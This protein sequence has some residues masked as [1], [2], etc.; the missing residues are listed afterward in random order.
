MKKI[1]IQPTIEVPVPMRMNIHVEDEMDAQ[2]TYSAMEEYLAKLQ[3]D[4][5]TKYHGDPRWCREDEEFLHD[6][7]DRVHV[8]MTTLRRDHQ[9]IVTRG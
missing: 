1:V 8:L 3:E 7:I 2:L 6:A 9:A 5:R 4:R